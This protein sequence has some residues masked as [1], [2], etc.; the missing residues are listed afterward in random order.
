M[1]E[2]QDATPDKDEGSSD[3]LTWI[4]GVGVGAIFLV[5]RMLR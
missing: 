5:A 2:A 1:V 4:L 3:Y